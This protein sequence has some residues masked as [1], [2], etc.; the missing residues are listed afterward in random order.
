MNLEATTQLSIKGI[1]DGL[2]LTFDTRLNFDKAVANLSNEIKNQGEF[3]RNSR[4]AVDLGGRIAT[5]EQLSEMQEIFASNGIALWAILSHREATRSAARDLGLATRLPGSQM[6]L[7]G[8]GSPEPVKSAEF[9]DEQ[10]DYANAIVMK[11]TVRSGRSLFFEG[12]VVILGDVNPGAE[13]IADGNIIVWGKLAGMV[14]AGANG[15]D[16][17]TVSALDLTP[18]QLRIANRITV[19]P[20]PDKKRVPIPETARIKDE[21]I[22][23]EAWNR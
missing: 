7:H 14:H 9:N 3:L 8:N 2:L 19:A 10:G 16:T 11:E 13:I 5:T 4:I 21:Q 20:P 18:T 22:V 12:H 23:A 6:D 15:D 17:A 1:R